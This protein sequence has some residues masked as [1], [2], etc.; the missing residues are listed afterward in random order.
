MDADGYEKMAGIWYNAIQEVYAN[1]W[2]TP[3]AAVAGLDDSD[4]D[5]PNTKCDVG[6]QNTVQPIKIQKGSGFNDSNY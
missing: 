2:L 4:T 1:C 6:T 3:P 5:G